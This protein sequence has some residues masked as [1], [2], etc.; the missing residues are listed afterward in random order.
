MGGGKLAGLIDLLFTAAPLL[1]PSWKQILGSMAHSF[2]CSVLL[3][4]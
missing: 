2:C 3:I 4:K 1:P